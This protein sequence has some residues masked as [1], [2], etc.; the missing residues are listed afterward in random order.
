M[1]VPKRDVV[2]KAVALAGY[3]L[4]QHQ[5]Q[6][7]ASGIGWS[8]SRTTSYQGQ[9]KWD[10]SWLWGI[11]GARG[12]EPF[13]WGCIVDIPRQGY[14]H[15]SCD[16]GRLFDNCPMGIPKR[17]MAMKSVI[18]AGYTLCPEHSAS[19]NTLILTPASFCLVG[20]YWLWCIMG[21]MS[22]EPFIWGCLVVI[23]RQGSGHKAVALASYLLC[24]YQMHLK[25][26]WIGSS[27]SCAQVRF[28][29][30]MIN[31]RPKG[32]WAIYLMLLYGYTRK[33]C[34]HESCDMGRLYLLSTSGQL[35]HSN[36]D[37]S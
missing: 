13:I 9:T 1:I 28:I 7:K 22:S 5:K 33:G 17:D 30:I 23:Q 4:C 14:C 16:T 31:H 15:E 10:S 25:Q 32:I 35:K 24:Q 21:P 37:P 6:L 2:M 26:Y 34:G 12:T 20:L 36:I 19:C 8:F 18:L 11:M 3:L 27:Y 29:L